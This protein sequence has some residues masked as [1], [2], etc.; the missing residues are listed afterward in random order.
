MASVEAQAPSGFEK[1][2]PAEETTTGPAPVE[3]GE[4]PR[5]ISGGLAHQDPSTRGTQDG[6]KYIQVVAPQVELSLT[7]G[8]AESYESTEGDSSNTELDDLC[9]HCRAIRIAR[10]QARQDKTR[11]LQ[12]ILEHEEDPS[13]RTTQIQEASEPGLQ[14][15]TPVRAGF[16]SAGDKPT[17]AEASLT[18]EVS[19]TR[20]SHIRDRGNTIGRAVT[21]ESRMHTRADRTADDSGASRRRRDSI[22]ERVSYRTHLDRVK[23]Q[24]YDNTP[25]DLHLRQLSDISMISK[26]K[27]QPRQIPVR[28]PVSE[29]YRQQ[30]RNRHLHR[31]IENGSRHEVSLSNFRQEERPSLNRYPSMRNAEKETVVDGKWAYG[32]QGPLERPPGPTPPAESTPLLAYPRPAHTPRQQPYPLTDKSFLQPVLPSVELPL[33][34]AQA[35]RARLLERQV[36]DGTGAGLRQILRRPSLGPH[37]D[38]GGPSKVADSGRPVSMADVPSIPDGIPPSSQIDTTDLPNFMIPVGLDSKLDHVER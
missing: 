31:A 4:A 12:S 28:P 36:L 30:P 21:P 27:L 5:R 26:S 37:A 24:N 20:E 13:L 18:F 35:G 29:M 3:E 8:V 32:L 17:I 15:R 6:P 1:R 23:P 16:P 10:R 9:Q 33:S 7:T 22:E 19:T 38:W 34:S 2:Q 11:R 25:R 14:T